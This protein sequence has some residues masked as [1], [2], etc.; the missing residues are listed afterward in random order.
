LEAE[1]RTAEAAEF[2]KSLDKAVVRDVLVKV[3][4]SGDAD[5]DLL[6]QEPS[7][8]I[9]SSR[10]QRTTSG[11]VMMGDEHPSLSDG[12]NKEFSEIYVC[13]QGFNGKYRLMLRRAWGN[14]TADKVTVELFNHFR[15]PNQTYQRKQVTLT[16]NS[17]MVAFELTDGRRQESLDE[18]VVANAAH[19]QVAL[20]RDFLAQQLNN[21]NDNNVA[22]DYLNSRDVA[23][24]A[25]GLPFV[26]QQRGVGFQ[27]VIVTL[28]EGAQLS[29]TAVISADRRYVRFS[30][31]PTFSAVSEVNTFSTLTGESGTS[32]GGT[33]GGGFS[34][35]VGGF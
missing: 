1:G 6:V 35:G 16:D 18:H 33:G 10:S 17:T 34:G 5:V 2:K 20:R 4:W 7:G 31:A 32:N 30:G 11:G 23:R 29:A 19:R 3:T 26:V 24:R 22:F 9:C 21:Q 25:N 14:P 27:P 8:T 28:P 12:H 13:P 15:G